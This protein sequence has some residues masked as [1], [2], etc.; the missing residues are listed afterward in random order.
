MKRF[1]KMVSLMRDSPSAMHISAMACACRSVGK[2]GERLGLEVDRFDAAV[3]LAHDA[4]AAAFGF[5]A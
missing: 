5:D 3:A 4:Q 1:S 2:A